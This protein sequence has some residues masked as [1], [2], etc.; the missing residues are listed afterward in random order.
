M[1][2]KPE[3]MRYCPVHLSLGI[4]E[5]GEMKIISFTSSKNLRN[6]IL[7]KYIEAGEYFVLFEKRTPNSNYKLE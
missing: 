4:L 5:Q 3:E 1:F 2:Y 7:S 6:T